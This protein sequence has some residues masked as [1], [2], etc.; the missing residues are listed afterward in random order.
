MIRHLVL[1][2]NAAGTDRFVRWAAGTLGSNVY[3]NIMPQYRPAHRAGRYPGL[4]RRV[5]AQEV[6][7]ALRWADEAGLTNPDRT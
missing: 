6:A 7:Q 5:T 4:N 1:P 2:Q 3:V